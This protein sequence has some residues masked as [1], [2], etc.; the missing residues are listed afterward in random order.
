MLEFQ[1][2]VKSRTSRGESGPPGE[3]EILRLNP[4]RKQRILNE[5]NWVDL[6]PGTLNLGVDHSIVE[7]LLEQNVHIVED[8]N[9]IHYPQGFARIPTK[10]EAYY[11][12][13]GKV[14]YASTSVDALVRRAKQ[15]VPGTVELF[16]PVNLREYLGIDD[17]SV[18]TVRV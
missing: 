6:A 8:A 17:G 4:Q 3:T 16:S 12:Y 7:R 1:G 9:N 14:I 2:T 13:L 10:R 18:V 5:T 11:Y 15:P